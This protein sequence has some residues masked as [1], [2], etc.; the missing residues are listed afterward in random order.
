MAVERRRQQVSKRR[1]T[2]AKL[3]TRRLTQ[4]EIAAAV[5]VD[6]STVSR[7][8]KALVA[9]WREEALADVTAVR[10]RELADLDAMEREA[11]MAASADVSPQE[12]ARLLEVRLRVKDRRSR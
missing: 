3:W 2:V 1:A 11:A 7:D 6:Q 9:A 5:G 10:A 12:L 8:I 4:E